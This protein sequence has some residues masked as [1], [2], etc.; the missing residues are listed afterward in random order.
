MQN[1]HLYPGSFKS[2]EQVQTKI[3][4]YKQ[5]F[6]KRALTIQ[7]IMT[8]LQYLLENGYIK[9]DDKMVF[10]KVGE[11]CLYYINDIFAN[12]ITKIDYSKTRG[13]FLMFAKQQI[14]ETNNENV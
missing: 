13:V 2:N 4:V 14:G 9:K 6:C 8:K 10:G 3:D 7:Y 12:E 1:V 5:L 11:Q